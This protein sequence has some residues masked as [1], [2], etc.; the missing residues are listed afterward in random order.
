MESARRAADMDDW[1][2]VD[3]QSSQEQIWLVCMTR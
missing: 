3:A 1:L 2:V